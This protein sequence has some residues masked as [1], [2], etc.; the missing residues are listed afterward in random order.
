MDEIHFSSIH[1]FVALLVVSVAITF[2]SLGS[3]YCNCKSVE[4]RFI[5][6]DE[7]IEDDTKASDVFKLLA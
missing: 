4:H 5:P 6:K 3:K 7:L 2:F 1:V